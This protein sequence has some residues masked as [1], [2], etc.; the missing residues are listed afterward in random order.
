M[1]IL[2]KN[3]LK[4]SLSQLTYHEMISDVAGVESFTWTQGVHLFLLGPEEWGYRITVALLFIYL[5]VG[6][7]EG[8]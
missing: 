4:G 7:Y 8:V 2:E 1:S 5:Y 6:V 3:Q